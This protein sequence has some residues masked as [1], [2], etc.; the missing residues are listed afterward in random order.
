MAIAAFASSGC[1]V[2]VAPT[3]NASN[4]GATDGNAAGGEQTALSGDIV[5]DGSS[6][7][8]PISAAVAEEFSKKH[9]SVKIPVGGAGTSSG[10]KRLIGGDLDVADASRPISEKEIAQLK[11][12]G[13]EYVELQVALD[14]LSVVV[15]KDNTWCDTIKISQLKELWK[16]GSTVSTWKQLDDKWPDAEI[17]LFGA[18]T[19]SGTFEY[20]TEAV[21]GKK[22][23]SREDYNQDED[24]NRL[25]IGVAGDVNALGYFGYSYFDENRDKIKAL[26]V[27]AG[28]DL[29]AAVEPTKDTIETGTYKP[30]SRPLFIYVNRKS[31][32]RPAVS[33]FLKYYLSD[34]G[35][36]LVTDV[37]CIRMN[38]DQLAA[39]RKRLDEALQ[40]V[41]R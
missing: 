40:T 24:D 11:E 25:V 36:K 10:F 12:K 16:S 41:S 18:G 29:T 37:H 28:D 22:G 31:L 1:S 34:E 30:L 27:A 23:D 21:V 17:K 39:S 14:G 26:K 20:F 3:E 8:L 2:K 35:Q 5:L 9:K 7:V 15:N 13:I 4:S 19:N 32:S 33:E 38:P 6:T